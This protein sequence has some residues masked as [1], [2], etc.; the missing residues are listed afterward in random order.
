MDE[1]TQRIVAKGKNR[2]KGGGDKK[3]GRNTA[4]CSY[5]RTA[6]YRKNKLAKLHKH[7]AVHVTD[8]CA[9]KALNRL[10]S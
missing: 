6:R 10:M 9:Q 5:Y 7:L 3:H 2:K 4:K 1:L 8:V